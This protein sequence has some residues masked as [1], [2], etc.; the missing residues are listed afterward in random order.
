MKP[1]VSIV[2]P[3]F[4]RPDRMKPVLDSVFAQKNITADIEVIILDNDP[5]ASAKDTVNQIIARGTR[6]PLIYGHEPNAGV[7]N[8]RNAGLALAKGNLIAFLDDDE[9]ATESWLSELLKTQQAT[10][11]DIVFGPVIGRLEQPAPHQEYIESTF[12]RTGSEQSGII[13]KFFGCGNSMF[14]REKF[15]NEKDLFDPKTNEIGG[16]DCELFTRV[17][18]KGAVFGWA[19]K[20][21]VFEDIPPSRATLRYNLIKAFSFGQGPSQTAWQQRKLAMLGFWMAVGAAQAIVYGL[22]A[23]PLWVLRTK[24]RAYIIDRAAQG[25]GKLLWFRGFEPRFYGTFV[26]GAKVQGTGSE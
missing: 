23:I 13:L 25:L 15:F 22:L 6:W 12:T 24:T 11:A 8:A 19:A 18:A 9:T 21:F 7:A 20:A 3:T 4:C 1:Q 16:E 17:E 5:K 10:S 14:S 2:I 26:L